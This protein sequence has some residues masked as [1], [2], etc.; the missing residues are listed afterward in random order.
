ML[1]CA[2]NPFV[3]CGTCDTHLCDM[4][5]NNHEHDDFGCSGQDLNNPHIVH[6]KYRYKPATPLSYVKV[7]FNLSNE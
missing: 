2:I 7:E 4:C 6:V 3:A 5:W 1:C